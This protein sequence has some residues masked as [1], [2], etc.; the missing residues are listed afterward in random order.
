[1]TGFNKAAPS[2]CFGEDAQG[3]KKIDQLKVACLAFRN[4]RNWTPEQMENQGLRNVEKLKAAMKEYLEFFPVETK[5]YILCEKLLRAF[6]YLRK[7]N[8][9]S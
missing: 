6:E 3:Q 8:A 2:V 7:G 4:F 9:R 5:L 1:M